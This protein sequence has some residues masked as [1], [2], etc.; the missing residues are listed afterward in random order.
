MKCY[1]IVELLNYS[2][3]LAQYQ[4]IYFSNLFLLVESNI[5]DISL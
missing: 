3:L 4:L 1:C 5:S 2:R